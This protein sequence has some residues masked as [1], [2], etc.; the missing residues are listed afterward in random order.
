MNGEFTMKKENLKGQMMHMKKEILFELNKELEME[1]SKPERKRDVE[2]ICWLNEMIFQLNY[3]DNEAVQNS[4]EASKNEMLNRIPERK[5]HNFK[6]I[7][8][9][10]SVAAACVAT[11]V[12]LNAFSLKTVGQNVFL[13]TY[14]VGDEAIVITLEETDSDEIPHSS[15][16]PYGMKAKCA[17]YGM[18][19]LTPSYIPEGFELIDFIADERSASTDIYFYYKKDD[20]ILN[21]EF[22]MYYDSERIPPFGTSTETYNMGEEDVIGLNMH[23]LKEG[24]WFKALFLRDNIVYS[25]VAVDCEYDE[26]RKVIESLVQ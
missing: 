23:I 14:K 5:P 3:S 12:V 22:F 26:F 11:V 6:R 24:D 2:R 8:K 4:L 19:P 18:R 15:A 10:V 13:E 17:E 7:N 1:L 9:R 25:I 16:D 21:F 20:V